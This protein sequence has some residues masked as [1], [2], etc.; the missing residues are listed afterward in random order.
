MYQTND[1]VREL[2]DNA[3]V[4]EGLARHASTHAAGIVI[5]NKHLSEYVPLYRGQHDEMV[6]QYH[7]K[8]IEKIGLIKMDFL[9]LETLTLI[10]SVVKLLKQ[11]SFSIFRHSSR[12][13]ED[14]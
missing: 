3:M 5:A 9:G 13:R 12:G 4:V 7:M 1:Q 8:I 10:D 2:L 11:G 6:T 14:F